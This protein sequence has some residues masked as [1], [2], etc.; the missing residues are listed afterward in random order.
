MKKNFQDMMPCRQRHNRIC[1]EEGSVLLAVMILALVL[2]ISGLAFF[3]LS[4]YDAG[5]C[6]RRWEEKQAFCWAESGVER[7]QWILTALWSKSLASIDSIGMV[8]VVEEIDSEGEA[9]RTGEE[10]IDFFHEVRVRSRGT[11]GRADRELLVLFEPGL[12]YALGAANDVTFHGG[13]NDGDWGDFFDRFNDVHVNG[14]I[15]YGGQLI[16][17]GEG[18]YD[19]AG[20]GDISLPGYFN[21]AASFTN[22]FQSLA[23][24]VFSGDQSFGYYS[25]SWHTPGDKQVIFVNGDVEI[26][27]NVKNY[28][29]QSVDVTIIATG[30]IT[31]NSGNSG[32]DDRL[33]LIS[34]GDV[35]MKGMGIQDEIWAV[36]LAGGTFTTEGYWDFAGGGGYIHGFV[37]AND[38]DMSGYDFIEQIHIKEGWEIEQD[39]GVIMMN[40]GISVLQGEVGTVPLSLTLKSW[41]EVA[42][43]E[44]S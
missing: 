6:Q 20:Q 12:K 37:L 3:S 33:V 22:R 39:I 18:K 35:T 15:Q 17:N 31:I 44:G 30:D 28:S 10:L 4:S 8:V 26:T 32:S 14:G 43:A 40:G 11:E 2:T 25:G 16:G 21:D 9:V 7:A 27:K 29:G 24:T 42:P 41:S 19:Q 38:V 5:L 23:D 34:L 13:A 1:S 36:I